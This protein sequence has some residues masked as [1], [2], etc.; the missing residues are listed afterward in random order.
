MS[1]KPI[2]LTMESCLD[3]L[4][5][6][7]IRDGQSHDQSC[8]W[9]KDLSEE[10]GRRRHEAFARLQHVLIECSGH[11]NPIDQACLD[12]P[13]CTKLKTLCDLHYEAYDQLTREYC[14]GS[15]HNNSTLP[16]LST[17]AEALH[18]QGSLEPNFS[19]DQ[20]GPC[21]DCCD[22]GE[23]FGDVHV[24]D[25]GSSPDPGSIR[26]EDDDDDEQV[27]SKDDV[28]K[29]R[30][31]CMEI[32]SDGTRNLYLVSGDSST[33]PSDTSESN[34]KHTLLEGPLPHDLNVTVRASHS[35]SATLTPEKA[36]AEQPLTLRGTPRASAVKQHLEQSQTPRAK[37]ALIG[38]EA[39][40][41]YEEPV[42]KNEKSVR[43]LVGEALN[44]DSTKKGFVYALRDKEFQLVK[45][46]RTERSVATRKQE[47]ESRCKMIYGLE[48]IYEVEVVAFK[49]LEKIVHRDLRPHR[50]FIACDCR[51]GNDKG[52]TTHQEYFEI[53]DNT[54]IRTLQL[55]SELSKK[56]ESWRDISP[57]EKAKLEKDW[58]LKLKSAPSF[59]DSETHDH[60]D[61][62]EKRWCELLD[63]PIPQVDNTSQATRE[64]PY[65]PTDDV[66]PG[67]TAAVPAALRCEVTPSKPPRSSLEMFSKRTDPTVF[68]TPSWITL[69]ESPSISESNLA[70][71]SHDLNTGLPFG[72]KQSTLP[73][74]ARLRAVKAS[75]HEEMRAYS[76]SGRLPQAN[77]D[78]PNLE[79]SM[80]SIDVKNTAHSDNSQGPYKRCSSASGRNAHSS[81]S[82]S[83]L[84]LVTKLLTEVQAQPVGAIL[85]DLWK[86]RWTLACCVIL[87]VYS[88]YLPPGLT[89]LT[90]SIFLPLLVAELRGWTDVRDRG[91][92]TKAMLEEPISFA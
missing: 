18:E 37:K 27:I 41:S 6:L 47:L 87:V 61:L 69:E 76:G 55:W 59:E 91:R 36:L 64:C 25:E 86:L 58:A 66:E 11:V 2:A 32:D 15:F 24:K 12:P 44:S 4:Q 80:T 40:R 71:S 42:A 5:H 30:K 53:D 52:Y 7:P 49:E 72:Q 73:F 68:Q 63:I 35:N 67:I 89:Y 81:A 20:G 60:H 46:G 50:W 65:F 9:A 83:E 13:E 10:A 70:A 8:H 31:K 16:V 26:V 84:A 54:A 90:W 88:P 92:F 75:S 77:E 29:T 45:I 23:Y 1:G 79:T 3:A 38:L 34:E 51:T 43:K 62:R 33:Q 56:K 39:D 48:F 82:E 85:T 28:S 57:G 14:K 78:Q 22:E 74:T 19:A 21:K 17:T